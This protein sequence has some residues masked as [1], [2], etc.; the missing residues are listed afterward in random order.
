MWPKLCTDLNGMNKQILIIGGGI[1]G[2]SVLHNLKKK[3]AVDPHIQIRLLEKNDYAGGTARTQKY[4]HCLFEE[5]PNGF[6][7]S[8]EST[9]RLVK[10][11]GLE[12]ELAPSHRQ[13]AIRYI[14]LNNQLHKLPSNPAG[15]FKFKLFSLYDKFRFPMEFFVPKGT[16]PNETVYEFGKRR[17]GENFSRF[18]LDPMV[19]GIFGGDARTMDLKSAFPRIYEIEQTYGSLIKG[20]IALKKQ[21]SSGKKSLAPAGQPGGHLT[22]FKGGMSQ[23][24]DAIYKRYHDSIHLYEE[25]TAIH[26]LSEG[27]SV[28][29][30]RTQYFA[31]EIYLCA[32]AHKAAKFVGN[33]APKLSHALAQIVYAPIAVVGLVY[34][35]QQFDRFP[36]GFGYLI[37]SSEG[38]QVLGVLFDSNIFPDRCDP[39]HFLFRVMLG[40]ARHPDILNLSHEELFT[41]AR[42]EIANTLKFHMSPADQIIKVWP[43]AIPQYNIQYPAL[44]STIDDEVKKIHGL[45]L[46]ANYLNGVSLN[47]CTA[48]AAAAVN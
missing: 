2:L 18:F 31:Q 32:P 37:P 10:E 11:L 40:G 20:M 38:T 1:S 43:E 48:N 17:I 42:K 45:H 27:F 41:L 30:T 46:V 9:L 47:D 26:R 15:M 16:N 4:P 7:D 5:G 29:T 22:S 21:K 44:K 24:T 12:G 19:S 34:R 23:L 36:E 33:F 14:C 6:L 25:V 28:E 13:S 39:E 8:K 35:R 3:Y